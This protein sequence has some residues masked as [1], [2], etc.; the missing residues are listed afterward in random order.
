MPILSV[1]AVYLQSLMH[2]HFSL[3]DAI[4]LLTWPRHVL[5]LMAPLS[6]QLILIMSLTA[7]FCCLE[8][9]SAT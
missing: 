1:P 8:L 9:F 4:I 7:G 5:L 2:A 6:L 3:L